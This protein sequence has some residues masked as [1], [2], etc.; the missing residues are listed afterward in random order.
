MKIIRLLRE[1]IIAK[2]THFIFVK[3]KQ[4]FRYKLL[5]KLSLYFNKNYISVDIFRKDYLHYGDIVVVALRYYGK[6]VKR[7]TNGYAKYY[8]LKNP[9]LTCIYC[10]STLN[11]DNSNTEH[12]I[13]ISLGGNNTKVNMIVCC[14][15][16]NAERGNEDFYTYLRKKNPKYR[17]KR[18]PFI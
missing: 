1:I 18:N 14:K 15:K 8:L 16:C 17:K 3:K 4:Y 7:R 9:G 5:I 12:I 6:N 11:N 2:D 10:G 13:P